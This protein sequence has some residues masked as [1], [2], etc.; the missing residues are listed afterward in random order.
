MVVRTRRV[1]VLCVVLLEVVVVAVAAAAPNKGDH[2]T[3]FNT[4]PPAH[5]VK[6]PPSDPRN[7][8]HPGGGADWGHLQLSSCQRGDGPH[9]R[10]VRRVTAGPDEHRQEHWEDNVGSH[11]RL[12]GLKDDLRDGLQQHQRDEDGH[13]AVEH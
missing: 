4:E 11:N 6:R 3:R 2:G 13:A 10:L 12:E 8:E 7:S 9:G 5:S 1:V